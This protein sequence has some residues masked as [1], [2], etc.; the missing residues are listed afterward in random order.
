ME[1][2]N[3][4]MQRRMDW[5]KIWLLYW[6]RVWLV[7]VVTA[8]AA[9]MGA[10]IYQVVRALNNEGQF[11]RV[12]SDYYITFNFDEYEN[13]VDYYNAY[14]WDNILRDDPIVDGALAVLP[15]D[16]TKDEIKAS[17]TGEMLGD[18]RILT[19]HATHMDPARAEAIA[20]AYTQSLV[21][22]AD[23]IEMLDT[24]ELWSKEECLPVVEKDLTPN[25]AAAGAVAGLVLGVILW[26]IYYI[27]DD[28]IYV[29]SDFTERFSTPCPLT[30][31]GT[32][33][34]TE[35]NLCKQELKANMDFMLR[36]EKGYYL[37]FAGTEN[38]SAAAEIKEKQK[39]VLD[40]VK[41]Y[42]GGIEGILT[43][44]GEDLNK[45]RYSNGAILMLPWGSKNGRITEK[46]VAFLEKQDCPIAG[47]I[48]YNADT[49][50]LKRYY[51]IQKEPK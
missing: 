39:L 33:T 5:K 30:F 1:K 48:L 22:F 21:L 32:L 15:A 43:L 27:L 35:S 23:K 20:D 18:Y 16:Y 45:L 13:S 11:Y 10:G 50:F 4:Y 31:L 25:A 14:T 7:I 29:E 49:K 19:V 37:V 28:S 26:S 47:A 3:S 9:A 17:I 6:E 51:N 34:K 36:E 44:Q 41:T 40:E 12:S 24:I 42:C 2:E 38:T 46:T 8:I